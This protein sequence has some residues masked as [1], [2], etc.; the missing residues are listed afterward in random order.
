MATTLREA[1]E[2]L[3]KAN[4]ASEPTL[5][6]I[7]LF[8]SEDE[9]RLV[10]VDRTAQPLGSDEIAPYYFSAAPA[11]GLIYPSA[12][13]LIRPEDQ[14]NASPPAGWGDWKDAVVIWEAA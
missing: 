1:A 9:I 13:A 10:E 3:A 14:E 8:P 5:D 4:L 2:S 7:Y 12:I 11:S 6:R